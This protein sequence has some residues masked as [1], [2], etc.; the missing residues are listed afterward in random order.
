VYTDY[1][2]RFQWPLLL[3]IILLC[4]EAVLG[5]QRALR[6]ERGEQIADW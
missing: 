1:G 4:A 3:A 6:R 2:Q 5:E